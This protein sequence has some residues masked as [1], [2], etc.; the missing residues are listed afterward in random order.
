MMLRMFG[1]GAGAGFSACAATFFV[2]LVWGAPW[3]AT[4]D[5]NAA[6]AAI[7]SASFFMGAPVWS[8]LRSN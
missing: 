7:A 5:S 6:S 2:V 3:A 4:A 1:A 8:V